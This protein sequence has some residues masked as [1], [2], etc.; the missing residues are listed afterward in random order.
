MRDDLLAG[1]EE[2][3]AACSQASQAGID[4]VSKARRTLLILDRKVV[5]SW[6]G[7]QSM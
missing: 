1:L 7:G 4:I 5:A 3:E 6:L 2:Y